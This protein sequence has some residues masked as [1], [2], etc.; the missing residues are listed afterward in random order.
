MNGNVERCKLIL[1]LPDRLDAT[2][3]DEKGE[4]KRPV[5]LHRAILGSIERFIGVLNRK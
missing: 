3:I 4:K 1:Y 5:M 2:Y